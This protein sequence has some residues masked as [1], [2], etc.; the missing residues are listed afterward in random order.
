[1]LLGAESQKMLI[2]RWLRRGSTVVL[3]SKHD[4]SVGRASCLAELADHRDQP[5][6]ET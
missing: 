4:D 2:H 5:A 1:M 6:S 3:S